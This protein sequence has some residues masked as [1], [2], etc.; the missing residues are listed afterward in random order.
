MRAMPKKSPG[1]G[2]PRRWTADRGP[3]D[4]DRPAGPAGGANWGIYLG[5][6]S[7]AMRDVIVK[8]HGRDD[9]ISPAG[10]R[11][12]IRLYSQRGGWEGPRTDDPANSAVGM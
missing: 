5:A 12:A 8:W 7:L 1:A 6:P 11:M 2:T 3:T 10:A 4:G 9:S